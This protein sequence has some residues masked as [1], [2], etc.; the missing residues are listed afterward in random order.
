LL[1]SDDASGFR[2]RRG[3][4]YHCDGFPWSACQVTATWTDYDASEFVITP[5]FNDQFN[6]KDPV[7]YNVN[8][9]F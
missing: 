4:H 2:I 9:L 8:L 6:Y 5:A 3:S 1:A 7:Q